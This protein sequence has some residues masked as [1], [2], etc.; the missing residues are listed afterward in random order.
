MS[1]DDIFEPVNDMFEEKE[2][3][4]SNENLVEGAWNTGSTDKKVWNTGV[5]D[6]KVWSAILSNESAWVVH[7]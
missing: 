7:G 1:F 6:K 2:N 3:K 4:E 5:P